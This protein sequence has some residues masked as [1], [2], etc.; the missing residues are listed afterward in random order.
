MSVVST[1]TAGDIAVVT[2]DSPP[3]N[4]LSVAVRTGLGEALTRANAD[5][6]IKAIVLRCKGKTFIAG[7]DLGELAKGLNR[8]E[9]TLS[10]LQTM[11]ESGKPVV[12]A[13]HGAA[14][15]GGYELAL[16][17]AARVAL[18]DARIGLP[19]VALGLLPGAGGT[20]RLT[21]LCGPKAALDIIVSGRHVS[22]QE[23]QSLG[24]ID[25]IVPDLDDAAIAYARTLA[26]TT[27]PAPVIERTDKIA[28]VDPELFA[29][30]RKDAERR[31]RGALAPAAII[32]CIE[33]ACTASP[34]DGLAFERAEFAK[35]NASDQR[36]A[37]T[38]YFFAEREARKIPG[39]PKDVA[40]Q[41]INQS[42]IIGAGLMGRGI[43]I[44]LA[45]AGID[46]ALVDADPEAAARG[47]EEIGKLY[48]ASV[49][50]GVLTGDAAAAAHARIRA[51]GYEDIGRPD[52]VIEAVPEIMTLKRDI[53][54]RLDAITPPH[55]IL[56]TNTSSL[57]IDH[58]AAS[59][60]RPDKV[61]G[62]H[63]FSPAHIMKLLE[64]VRGA[65]T[66]P[67]AIATLMALATRLKKIPV[68]AGNCDGFIGNRM[69]QYYTGQSEFLMEQ[70]VE[71]ARIDAVAEAFG[72]PMGP[73]AMRDMAGIDVSV[74]VRK[75]RI[76]TLPPGERLSPLQERMFEAGRLGQKNGRGFYRYEGRKRLPDPEAQ[77]I[78]DAAARELGIA[79][80][81]F[82]D[83]Q[84]RDRLFMPLVNEGAKELEE[85]IAIR[86]SDI[87]VTYVNGYGFPRLRGGPMHWGESIGLDK[88]LAMAEQLGADYGPRWR[89]SQLLERL[90][91]DRASWRDAGY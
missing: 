78:I 52:I 12:A 9:P 1:E 38:Y 55:T 36:K 43:A 81:E 25:A 87:D 80:R 15:G 35:L 72:M 62:A 29:A 13:I 24:A 74:L 73:V 41:E 2:I 47:R 27:P 11:L 23:A 17:C 34:Q 49:E 84:I 50:R 39:L 63:F 79:K 82:T 58:I 54:A 60:G 89:P 66:G 28:S 56:A 10:A 57:N 46:V 20:Q 53:F 31:S 51:S 18:A 85:G 6:A 22:A 64:I 3:V 37:L 42:A 26:A 68:L 16:T 7:A 33:Q 32:D 4:T 65:H 14:L 45:N 40:T 30:A 75:E 88:V 76:K 59:T 71:P 61:I 77:A 19:E 67:S 90:V 21:R 86:A 70:G 69:L 44:V 83:E 91:R 5:A 8:Q 48:A